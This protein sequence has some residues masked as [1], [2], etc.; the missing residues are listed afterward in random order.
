MGSD[1]VGF[2]GTGVEPGYETVVGLLFDEFEGGEE[3]T[4]T[5]GF[6]WGVS[7]TITSQSSP[8]SRVPA[9]QVS[10]V[11]PIIRSPPPASK[12]ETQAPHNVPSQNSTQTHSKPPS[13]QS[14][15]TYPSNNDT[16]S[17]TLPVAYPAH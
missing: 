6:L 14:V 9:L 2:G 4:V 5:E 1:R 8:V 12:Q 7:V 17:Y 16:H 13:P 15:S 11:S 10:W 3:E